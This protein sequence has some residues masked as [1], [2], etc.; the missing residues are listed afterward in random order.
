MDPHWDH[1]ALVLEV[2]PDV[3]PGHAR[4]LIEEYHPVYNDQ[5][6]EMVLGELFDD[7]SYPKVEKGAGWKLKAKSGVSGVGDVSEGLPSESDII[8]SASVDQPKPTK[9]L[10]LV[11]SQLPFT[12]PG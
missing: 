10:V 5:V 12:R 6:A 4:E 2:L 1:L 11:S 8:D 9:R 3:L 7:P